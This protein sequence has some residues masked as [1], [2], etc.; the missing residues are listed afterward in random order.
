MQRGALVYGADGFIG[1]HLVKTLKREGHWVSGADLKAPKYVPTS[2]DDCRL[3]DLREP[4][5]SDN[6][7]IRQKLGWVP[8]QPLADGLTQT[9]KWIV[10]K[11][12]ARPRRGASGEALSSSDGLA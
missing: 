12:A 11:V 3:G 7:L 1:G 8:S 2:A 10:K 6:A 4:S 9:Y 5:S